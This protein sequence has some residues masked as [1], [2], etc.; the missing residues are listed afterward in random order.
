MITG[1]E[2]E[3]V[4]EEKLV[5]HLIA[6]GYEYV[7]INDVK[8]LHENFR[9]QINKHNAKRLNGHVLS[10]KEFQRLMIKISGKGV[11][12]SSEILRNLQDI[13]MDDGTTNYIELFN[14]KD[15]CKNEFQVTNQ[16]TMIGKYENRYD[17]TLL[18]NGLPLVQIE[19]K[20]RSIDFKEAFNQVVRYKKHSFTDLYRFVQIFIISNGTDTKYFAN[21][22]TDLNFQ[23]C[24]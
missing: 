9:K 21:S 14:H 10:D 24:H 22:D 3:K 11:F 7:T 8:D 4:L 16:V 19:L 1:Y 5:Q 2:S 23:Y 6:D 13:Q 20:K 17:V 15:W 18:V 12:K